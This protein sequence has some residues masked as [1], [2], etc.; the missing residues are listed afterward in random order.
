MSKT[1]ISKDANR[2][3][4]EHLNIMGAD[5]EYVETQGIV[6][7]YLSNHPDVFLCKM[8][9]SEDAPVFYA[10]AESLGPEYPK[11]SSYNAACT[12]KFFI[13]N[14]DITAPELLQAARDM[15]MTMINVKQGYA[16]CNVAIV[17]ENS[18]ITSDRG[19]AAACEEHPDLEVLLI[20]P[21]YIRLDGFETGFIGGATG[22][23]GNEFVFN[24]NIGI[25]P[26]FARI[27]EFIESRGLTPKW[28]PE[29]QLTDIGSIL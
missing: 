10:P 19:I 22:I 25:H 18:I 27:L 29:Y 23:V 15:G 3:L 28:F 20:E 8:G 26:D 17:D 1:Y 14:F 7:K 4:K 2:R 13:H 11:D 12:G 21:G 16:K 5:V 9:I 6:G 24:G